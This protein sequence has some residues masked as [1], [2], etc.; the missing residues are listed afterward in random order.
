MNIHPEE[1]YKSFHYAIRFIPITLYITFIPLLLCMI[2]GG[3]IA[4]L[5]VYRVRVISAL[6]DFL[7]SIIKG[8]P[9]I[10]F[11]VVTGLLFATRFDSL[12]QVLHLSIRAKDVDAI[13]LATFVLTFTHI[14]SVS[15]SFRGALLSV[16]VGQYEAGYS[17]GMTKPQTFL[18]IIFPQTFYVILPS[19]TNNTIGLLK[20][21]SIVYMIGVM[22]ILNS[23]LKPA[24]ATYAFLE[25]YI[26]AAIIYWILCAGIEAV[27]RG[28][29]Y[30]FGKYHR[31]IIL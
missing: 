25:S 24:N 12:A 5:R 27:G 1:I 26:A 6:L 9:T 15:E 28:L 14:P 20:G 10:L 2:F 29:E 22:D 3:I 8:I 7:V 16:P 19:L 17:V 13:Y 23:A 11:L 31:G 21:S 18:R 4:L 30:Y